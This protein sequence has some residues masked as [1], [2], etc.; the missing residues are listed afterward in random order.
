MASSARLSAAR[1]ETAATLVRGV[2]ETLHGLGI[3]NAQ[4]RVVC[5]QFS[6]TDAA[7]TT[8]AA[9]IDGK[10]FAAHADGIDRVEFYVSM[11]KGEDPKPL[12]RVASGGEISRVMLAMKGM[13]AKTDRLPMLVFD[14]ID[15]GISGRIARKV[16]FAMHELAAFHQII[17]ITHL[18]QIAALADI[19]IA[20][21]KTE[22]DGRATVTAAALTPEQ[23]VGEVAKLIGGEAVTAAALGSARELIE[24]ADR[25][26]H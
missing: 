24:A 18:P 16:G 22:S 12:A 26:E 10:L 7:D 3:P 25:Q 1:R 21:E 19:H 4:F 6:A 17:A 20:V 23:R 9:E 13:L 14:E 8:V 11:N 15:A 5:E 2:E